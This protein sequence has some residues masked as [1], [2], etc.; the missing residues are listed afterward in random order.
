MFSELVLLFGAKDDAIEI[1]HNAINES[2]FRTQIIQVFFV[3]N[4]TFDITLGDLAAILK[5]SEKQTGRLVKKAC[6]TD[7]QSYLTELRLKNA[8]RLLKETDDELQKIAEDIGYKSYNGFYLAFKKGFG[9]TP[10]VY[11]KKHR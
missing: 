3:K 11:R 1:N 9:M 5:L 4:Y 7:F 2:D 6:G 10:I 8:K